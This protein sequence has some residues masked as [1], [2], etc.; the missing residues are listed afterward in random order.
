[1]SRLAHVA[2]YGTIFALA[3][4]VAYAGTR[5]LFQD[6]AGTGETSQTAEALEII[7]A[8]YD[9]G[10]LDADAV[11][12]ARFE[13]HNRGPHPLEIVTIHSDCACTNVAV[14]N[15]ELPPGGRTY[16]EVTYAAA[17][18]RHA[19]RSELTI[20][21]AVAGQG[22]VARSEAAVTAFVHPRLNHQPGELVFCPGGPQTQHLVLEGPE[23]KPFRVESL[24]ASHK[25]FQ[26]ELSGDDAEVASR[27]EI[28][29]EFTA[30]AWEKGAGRERLVVRTSD[31][32][33]PRLEVSLRVVEHGPAP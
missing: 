13:L 33:E 20:V 18:R 28:A 29:V 26:A 6:T 9:L 12:D 14:A 15:R 17:G 11:R 25:A 19:D 2:L 10:E 8:V 27:W 32:I 5:V 31:E 24:I 16:L 30:D 22:L 1:M 3:A 4:L 21:Y 23:E 7:P